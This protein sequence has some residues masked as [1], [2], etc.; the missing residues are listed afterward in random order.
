[1]TSAIVNL[2]YHIGHRS[3]EL[4]TTEL[5]TEQGNT[6]QYNNSIDFSSR[7]SLAFWGEALRHETNS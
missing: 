7:L 6:F 3:G 2:T 1:M 4:K 5:Q